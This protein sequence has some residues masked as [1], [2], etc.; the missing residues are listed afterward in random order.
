MS[1]I[2]S[3]LPTA[4]TT[5]LVTTLI[6]AVV[7]VIGMVFTYLAVTHAKEAKAEAAG[8]KAEASGAR[9]QAT[10]A[11]DAVNHRHEHGVD[12]HGQPTTPKLFDLVLDTN[13][14]AVA[15]HEKVKELTEWRDA[16]VPLLDQRLT[17]VDA[18]VTTSR[19]IVFEAMARADGEHARQHDELRDEIVASREQ[20]EGVMGERHAQ[21]AAIEERLGHIEQGQQAAADAAGAQ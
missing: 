1:V 6:G 3:E 14:L 12:E 7:S 11:N 5:Q 9:E 20:L 8:A 17:Q 4:A 19:Q 2:P 10:Q 16:A 21:Y 13:K 18:A 15:T